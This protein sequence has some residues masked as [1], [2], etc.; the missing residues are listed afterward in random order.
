MDPNRVP[1]IMPE[2]DNGG[3]RMLRS[4]NDMRGCEPDASGDP[5]PV[6]VH[7]P[8]ASIQPAQ[9][10][11]VDPESIGPCIYI[12]EIDLGLFDD[13]LNIGEW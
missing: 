10:E 5:P 8:L 9:G 6:T 11:M 12:P 3:G 13:L 4:M 1:T 2:R 7:A